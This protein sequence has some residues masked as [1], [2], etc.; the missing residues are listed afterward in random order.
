MITK[1][2]LI[3]VRS[4]L[5]LKN[6]SFKTMQERVVLFMHEENMA[7]F[8]RLQKE[9]IIAIVRGLPLE[10][11]LPLAKALTDGGINMIEVTFNQADPDSFGGTADAIAALCAEFEGKACIGA[12][13]VLSAQQAKL[14]FDAGA[15]YAVMPNTDPAV[16]KAVKELGMAAFPGAMTA[17]EVTV[18]RAAGAD[19]VKLFPIGNLG[20][21]YLKAL[22]APLPHI[23]LVAVGGVNEKNI[24]EFLRAGAVGA[25]VG[26]NLVNKDWIESGQWYKITSLAKAYREAVSF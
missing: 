23:P 2:F 9:K 14:A 18:A 10:Y 8:E 16:I 17:S 11:M 21:S 22:T 1:G 5:S 20:A 26:G 13:T 19:A 6:T 3:W 4:F 15:Q 25:G 12:G 7:V 24:A